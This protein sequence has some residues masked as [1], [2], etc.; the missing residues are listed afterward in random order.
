MY[1]LTFKIQGKLILSIVSKEGVSSIAAYH[2]IA[3]AIAAFQGYVDAFGRD[4]TWVNS[5]TLGLM[6]TQPH[7]VEFNEPAEA[8]EPFLID[9]KSY[10]YSGMMGS[11]KVDGT[12]LRD[13]FM[14]GRVIVD[15]WKEC[16]KQAGLIEA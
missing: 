12:P 6:N 10:S 15:M 7:L 2:T 11:H 16:M 3:D 13:D 14:E 9:R 5:A 8:I 1:L 4:F